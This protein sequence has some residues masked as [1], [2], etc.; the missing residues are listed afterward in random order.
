LSAGFSASANGW[1]P[2]WGPR[3]RS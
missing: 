3:R 2:R 1:T